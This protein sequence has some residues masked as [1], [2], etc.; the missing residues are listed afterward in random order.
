MTNTNDILLK[1]TANKIEELT[2]DQSKDWFTIWLIWEPKRYIVWLT[3]NDGN[4]AMD[5]LAGQ[6]I[7]YSEMFTNITV[8][9]RIDEET[10]EFYF[11]IGTSTTNLKYAITLWL[12]FEQLAIW[13]NQEMVEI[14]TGFVR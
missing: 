13:D 3:N 12:A 7:E 2:K 1:A 9:G 11:D 8:W 10:N 14:R 4:V 5:T 6:A